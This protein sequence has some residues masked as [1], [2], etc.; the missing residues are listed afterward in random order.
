MDK[1]SIIRY[2]IHGFQN[3]YSSSNLNTLD[4]LL[5][6]AHPCISDMENIELMAIPLE[7]EVRK[8]V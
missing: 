4:D 2:F 8:T 5:G 6:I 7:D 3:L 1:K